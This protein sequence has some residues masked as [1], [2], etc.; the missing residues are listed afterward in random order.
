MVNHLP[1]KRVKS[2]V[3]VRGSRTHSR[4]VSTHTRAPNEWNRGMGDRMEAQATNVPNKSYVRLG[5]VNARLR[6]RRSISHTPHILV[7]MISNCTSTTNTRA[8]TIHCVLAS[9]GNKTECSMA[10]NILLN[11]HRRIERM[12][13]TTGLLRIT[14]SRV[15]IIAR[16]NVSLSKWNVRWVCWQFLPLTLLCS[17]ISDHTRSVFTEFH[18]LNYVQNLITRKTREY[19]IDI[20]LSKFANVHVKISNGH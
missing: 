18:T 3:A 5:H 13:K 16:S 1:R 11:N 9:T 20:T 2:F 7:N 8:P 10:S 6:R 15:G 17:S 12:K 4:K 19:N 14:Q